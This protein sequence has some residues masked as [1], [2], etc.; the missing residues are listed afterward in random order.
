MRSVIPAKAGIQ[1]TG[2]RFGMRRIRTCAVI[3]AKAGIQMN[4]IRPDRHKCGTCSV[5]PAKA[6]IHLP[7]RGAVKQLQEKR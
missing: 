5:I 3:P 7:G 2:I 6:G 4:E 1:V